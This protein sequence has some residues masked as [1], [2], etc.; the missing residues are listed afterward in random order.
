MGVIDTIWYKIPLLFTTKDYETEQKKETTIMVCKSICTIYSVLKTKLFLG[1]GSVLAAATTAACRDPV[2]LGKREAL[3]VQRY[4]GATPLTGRELFQDVGAALREVDNDFWLRVWRRD[5]FDLTKMGYSVVIDD[6]R[7]PREAEY[8]K[9]ADP[10]L[11]LVRVHASAEV[12]AQRIG[13]LVATHDITEQAWKAAPFDI[14][15]DTTDLT[16]ERA[17]WQLVDRID[18]ESL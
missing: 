12:R 18:E 13:G 9:S 1:S 2:I 4:S 16:A 10:Q 5:Y 17:F 14:Q 8:L 6:V 15:I 11:L 7:L 3:T